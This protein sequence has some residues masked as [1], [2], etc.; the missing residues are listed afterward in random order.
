MRIDLGFKLHPKGYT[1]KHV[2]MSAGGAA[3]SFL[4]KKIRSILAPSR[5]L[6]LAA[7]MSVGVAGALSAAFAGSGAAGHHDRLGRRR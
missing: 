2:L 4:L 6:I 5:S 3:R 7:A 1:P